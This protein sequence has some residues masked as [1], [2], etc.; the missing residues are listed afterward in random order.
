MRSGDGHR[1]CVCNEK[2]IQQSRRARFEAD[3]RAKSH[4]F[5]IFRDV[6]LSLCARHPPTGHRQ[7]LSTARQSCR[8]AVLEAASCD[9]QVL[10]QC[11][12]SCSQYG[13]LILDAPWQNP[14]RLGTLLEVA[15]AVGEEYHHINA[16]FAHSAAGPEFMTQAAMLFGNRLEEA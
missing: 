12:P 15:S 16:S 11:Q 2:V 9:E 3:Y 8:A 7:Q 10:P 5:V 14:S 4:H 1:P 6:A 13:F